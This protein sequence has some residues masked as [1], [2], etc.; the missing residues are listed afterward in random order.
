M[1]SAL[2]GKIA[3]DKQRSKNLNNC[4]VKI[5]DYLGSTYDIFLIDHITFF[6][7]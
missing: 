1:F 3:R 4:L 7:L 2:G 6:K 5:Q